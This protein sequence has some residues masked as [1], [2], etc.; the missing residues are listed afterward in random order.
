MTATDYVQS[1]AGTPDAFSWLAL[2][3]RALAPYPTLSPLLNAQAEDLRGLK[4]TPLHTAARLAGGLLLVAAMLAPYITSGILISGAR[5]GGDDATLLAWAAIFAL[6]HIILRVEEW[7]KASRGAAAPELS[8]TV[9]TGVSIFFSVLTAGFALLI[10]VLGSAPGAWWYFTLFF[11]M[12]LACVA[13][14]IMMIMRR[15]ANAAG[16]L[17]I[18]H[19]RDPES[20]LA[21]AVAAL[22]DDERDAIKKDISDALDELAEFGIITDAE[23]AKAL[24]RDIGSFS[25]WRWSHEQFSRTKK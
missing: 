11:V 1:V 7:V 2:E 8:E 10:A 14:F 6:A 22:S 9:F 19:D 16:T 18:N 5:I 25:T 12:T 4:T 21:A 20:A 3:E 13:S 17:Y 23:R 15:K 24:T